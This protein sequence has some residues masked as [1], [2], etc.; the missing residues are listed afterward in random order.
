MAGVMRHTMVVR[1]PDTMEAVALLKGEKLPDWATDLVHEDNLESAKAAKAS[2][3]GSG[4]TEATDYASKTPEELQALADERK[5][6]VG[7]TGKNGN[8]LKGDLVAALEA[9][10]SKS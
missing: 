5:L 8:V 7:G 3:S 4:S 2:D 6:T 10:D 9:D 1:N